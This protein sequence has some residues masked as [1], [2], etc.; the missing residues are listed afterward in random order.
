VSI[1]RAEDPGLKQLE[2]PMLQV[3]SVAGK[4]PSIDEVLEPSAAVIQ[5]YIIK[6]NNKFLTESVPRIEGNE[7]DLIEFL[8]RLDCS[9]E[10]STVSTMVK[11]YAES[12][13]LLLA[14][15]KYDSLYHE[16]IRESVQT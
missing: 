4:N 11:Q 13:K 5:D 9:N 16:V 10:Q 1:E 14:A 8:E 7:M 15:S 3:T 2:L 6:K 12:L